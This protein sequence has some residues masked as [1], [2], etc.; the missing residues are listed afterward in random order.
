VDG[1]ADRTDL[2]AKALADIESA[3]LDLIEAGSGEL[4][5]EVRPASRD[6]RRVLITSGP[7]ACVTVPAVD[8]GAACLARLN[9]HTRPGPAS[10]SSEPDPPTGPRRYLSVPEVAARYQVSVH[11]VRQRLRRGQLPPPLAI[12]RRRLW[13][14]EDLN[15][16][17]GGH[18]MMKPG[19]EGSR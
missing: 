14:E 6:R 1:R 16:W 13:D 15:R 4:R 7:T 19:R 10:L 3:L 9:T 12:G 11:A 17:D 5:V 18:K 8:L 2:A